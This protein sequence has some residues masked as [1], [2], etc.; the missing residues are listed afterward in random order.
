MKKI[1]CVA[2]L[3]LACATVSS[4]AEDADKQMKTPWDIAFGGA[5][6]SDYIIRGIS[7]SN[8]RPAANAYFE[9]RYN[10]S[11]S[12][13][14]YARVLGQSIELPNRAE[15]A[16]EYYAG[17][18]PTFGKLDLDFGIWEHWLVGGQCI[19]PQA[20]GGLCGNPVQT[21]GGNIIR[22]QWSFTEIFAKAIYNVDK[23]FSWGGQVFWTPSVLNVGDQAT[24]VNGTAKYILPA[25]FP[26]GIGW[27]ISADVGHWFR[28]M[29][30]YPSYSNWD[31]GLAFTWKQFTLDFR[32]SDT[33]VHSCNTPRSVS[34]TPGPRGDECRAT[35]IAKLSFDMSKENLR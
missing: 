30:P 33:N 11:N 4:L 32:Y 29:T 9:P 7:G 2:T 20:I 26:L 12:L 23:N 1:G 25:I 34:P 19:N 15:A 28:E 16:I 18:R 31:V 27:F 10:F 13:Q 6:M 17:A 22:A 3:V 35:F 14:F 21:P 5:L 8:H 24:Y